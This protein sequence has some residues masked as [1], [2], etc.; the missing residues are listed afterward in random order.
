[1]T[2][3]RLFMQLMRNFAVYHDMAI[4]KDVSSKLLMLHQ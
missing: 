4:L 1:M 2:D 3:V